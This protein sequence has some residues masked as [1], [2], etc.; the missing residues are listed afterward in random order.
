LLAMA[1]DALSRGFD[2]LDLTNAMQPM[3]RPNVRESLL[4]LNQKYGNHLILRVSL[5]HYSQALHECERGENTW[6]KAIEGLNWL[7]E[8]QFSIAIAGRTCWDEGDLNYGGT[9]PR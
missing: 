8:H 2:V 9:R 7:S 3:Q 5:D 6:I 4:A 1:E